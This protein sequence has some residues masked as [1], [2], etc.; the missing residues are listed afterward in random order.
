MATVVY[1][2]DIDRCVCKQKDDEA[3][4]LP[5][6]L[7]IFKFYATN[8]SFV[9]TVEHQSNLGTMPTSFGVADVTGKHRYVLSFI[10][11]NPHYRL[12]K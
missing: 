1:H 4:V 9:S 7:S 3:I 10:E 6:S 2:F 12:T 11:N 8:Y 5:A